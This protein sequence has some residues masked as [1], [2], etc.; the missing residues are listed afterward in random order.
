M[1]NEELIQ[2]MLEGQ[3]KLQQSVIELTQTVNAYVLAADTRVSQLEITLDV[4]KTTFD[5]LIKT[6]TIQQTN[7]KK[8]SESK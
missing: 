6:I 8:K 3:I 7:G 5:A 1:S 2:I 4:L